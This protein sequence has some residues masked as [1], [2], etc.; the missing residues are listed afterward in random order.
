ME[1]TPTLT[2]FFFSWIWL[3]PTPSL[4]THPP[5]IVCFPSS[6]F[7]F[8]C[9]FIIW[10]Y[11]FLIRVMNPSV[12]LSVNLQD[13][14]LARKCSVHDSLCGG[15]AEEPTWDITGSGK[16]CELHCCLR[17]HCRDWCGWGLDTILWSIE[18]LL[19]MAEVEGG[20]C[21]ATGTSK[22]TLH[23]FTHSQ[24]L[25]ELDFWIQDV[26][27]LTNSTSCI[28]TTCRHPLGLVLG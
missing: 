5:N 16:F 15:T 1:N 10:V 20:L 19:D 21:T 3:P 26:E 2:S 6:N 4:P 22:R 11:F 14:N 12:Y 8:E 13:P 17:Y 28:S 24:L 18:T 23:T 27:F 25:S 9:C 7:F